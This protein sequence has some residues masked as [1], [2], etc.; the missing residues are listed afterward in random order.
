M[1]R[2]D[3]LFD[4]MTERWKDVDIFYLEEHVPD[5]RRAPGHE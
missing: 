4:A 2:P 3:A 1:H 5:E